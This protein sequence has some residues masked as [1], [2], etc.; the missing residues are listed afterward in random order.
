M[1]WST[2]KKW[3]RNLEKL[4][5]RWREA[6]KKLKFYKVFDNINLKKLKGNLKHQRITKPTEK[7]QSTMK[8]SQLFDE[9]GQASIH[10]DFVEELGF[11]WSK[12]Y[13]RKRVNFFS[14]PTEHGN[15]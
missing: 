5:R 14:R 8:T 15:K 11:C 12:N 3:L 6:E 1:Y 4:N 7:V 13:N 9:K 10:E 2:A